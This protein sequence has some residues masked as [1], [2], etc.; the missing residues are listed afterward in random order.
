MAKDPYRST[1]TIVRI[2]I[3]GIV[4]VDVHVIFIAITVHGVTS[5]TMESVRFNCSRNHSLLTK[6]KP[7]SYLRVKN[8][9]VLSG[10]LFNSE[11][12]YE[13]PFCG[14]PAETDHYSPLNIS[15]L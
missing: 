13:R 3:L 15:L 12:F 2:V 10:S 14:R 11:P 8:L 6:I 5:Y 4:L 9:D 1:P 7:H